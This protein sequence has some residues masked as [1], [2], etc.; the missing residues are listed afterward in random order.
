MTELKIIAA[1]VIKEEYKDELMTIFHTVVEETRKEAGC[2][3][4]A[5]HQD[6]KNSKKYI[7]LEEWKDQAAI[8]SHNASPHFQ[9]FAKGIEGKIESLSIDVIRE[10]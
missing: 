6:V 3:A 7:I 5:L 10:I 4:Y 1:I 2:I 8:D 9:A